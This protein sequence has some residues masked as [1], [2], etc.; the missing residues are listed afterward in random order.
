MSTKGVKIEI[1]PSIKWIEI[2]KTGL[3]ILR[4]YLINSHGFK[5]DF[6]NSKTSLD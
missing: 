6:A 1:K 3:F 5:L 2:K 4:K